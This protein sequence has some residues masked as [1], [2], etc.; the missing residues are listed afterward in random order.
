MKSFSVSYK[1]SL[2]SELT[3]PQQL[4][5]TSAKLSSKSELV[6]FIREGQDKVYKNFIIPMQSK[7]HD[8]RNIMDKILANAKF[9]LG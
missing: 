4:F 8:D 1:T 2:G 6:C 5:S 7:S 9:W 3:K